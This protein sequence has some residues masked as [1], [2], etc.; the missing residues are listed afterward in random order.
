MYDD[1]KTEYA[2]DS[3]ENKGKTQENARVQKRQE[4]KKP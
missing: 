1:T 2:M 3:T 4:P